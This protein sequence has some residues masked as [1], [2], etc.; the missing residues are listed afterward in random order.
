MQSVRV[1]LGKRSYDILVGKDILD[2]LGGFI[3]KL[4]LGNHAYIITNPLVKRKCSQRL[5]S[6]LK[7]SGISFTLRCVPDTEESKS[8]KVLSAVIKDLASVDLKKRTFIIALGG[9]VVGDL[10]GFLAA[11]YKRGIAYVQVPTTLLAQVDSAI[12]GKTAVDL[13]EG[14]NLVGAFYQP[15]LVISDV[16]LLRSLNKRQLSAGLAEVIKYGIIKDKSLFVYLERELSRVLTYQS[17]ALERIVKSSSKIKADIVSC[18]EKEE[19][20]L[21]TILN[22][23]HTIGHAVESASGFKR[24]NHGEA[25]ALGMLVAADISRSLKLIDKNLYL[26]IEA[27]IKSAGL[28]VK[29]EKLSWKKIIS[30]S[31]RDK[32]FIGSKNRFVLSAGL[33][34]TK[35][36]E[37]IPLKIIE[38]AIRARS[39]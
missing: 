14:K 26:R 13:K 5:I 23:G 39:R 2:C 22:F 25:V 10:S 35:I 1:K 31:H 17:S 36:I 37:N 34:K 29:I 7:K 12:G 28:P 6:G 4:D 24:Y 27:L 11:I 9:G 38:E 33:G 21:R 3:K 19:K 32:K 16:S 20:G 30:A 8:I 18:D 15:S